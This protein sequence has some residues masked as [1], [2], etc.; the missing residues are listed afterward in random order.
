[1]QY[2][3]PCDFGVML[4]ND[5]FVFPVTEHSNEKKCDDMAILQWKSNVL[6][7]VELWS[8]TSLL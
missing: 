1:M 4:D 6:Q 7:A 8:H 5:I 3:L 2:I